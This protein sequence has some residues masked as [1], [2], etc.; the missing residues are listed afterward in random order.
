MRFTTT[1]VAAAAA[2]CTSTAIAYTP[3]D[4][5]GTDQLAARGLAN[6]KAYEKTAN[7]TCSTETANV[8][9]EWNTLS[10]GEKKEYIDAVLCLQ[11]KPAISGAIAPGAKSRYDDFVATH[12]NQTLT[13]HGTANFLTWHR[14]FVK[15]YETALRT[16]CNY[17]GYQPYL[18]WGQLALDPLN[19]PVFS[20]DSTSMSGNGA[21]V[22]HSGAGVPSNQTPFITVP[23]GQGGGCLTSGPFANMTVNL[24]PISPALPS[25][26][27]PSNPQPDGLGHNPR[28]LR[29]DISTWA[30]RTNLQDRNST[31]LIVENT[32]IGEFQTVM[33]GL[34]AQGLLGVHTA[35]HFLVGGDPGGDLFASPGDPYFFLHHAQIDRTYWIWQNQQLATRQYALA[36]TLTLNNSPPSRNGTLD[37]VLELGVNAGAIT[38]REAMSTLGGGFCYIYE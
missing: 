17:T 18:N 26:L 2:S 8:R 24:G 10:E 37:D 7:F 29:R 35:G 3:A 23:P 6:L 19:A 11:S 33:Q 1:A 21:Y 36:G 22:N 16:E 4:T 13:I 20:G 38:I 30:A 12:I 9:K 27:V 34:F 28:C 32:D 5:S 25:S 31:E 15:T 14:Y